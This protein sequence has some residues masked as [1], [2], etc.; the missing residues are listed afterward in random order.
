MARCDHTHPDTGES[1][2]IPGSHVDHVT[3]TGVLWTDQEVVAEI[4]ERH[5]SRSGGTKRDALDKAKALA[6]RLN[7]EGSENLSK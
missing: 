6:A 5:A 7:L 2:L 1:C 4:R 3:K